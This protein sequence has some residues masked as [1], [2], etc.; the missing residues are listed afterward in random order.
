MNTVFNDAVAELTE[1]G[2]LSE[3]V[4][5]ESNIFDL[6][7]AVDA[8]K[9]HLV[10]TCVPQRKWRLVVC[11]DETAA[12]DIYEGCRFSTDEVVYYP[13]KD[14]LFYQSDIRSN[15]LN[16]ER[17][18]A[19]A[20]LLEKESG[21]VVTT[22][23]ALM[24]RIPPK[25]V[26]LRSLV[27]IAVDDRLELEDMKKRLLLLGYEP[28]GSVRERGEFAARGG[29]VDVFPLNTMHPFRIEF[30][31]DMVDSIR[32]FDEES[33][34][35]ID[36]VDVITIYPVIEVTLEDE[37]LDDALASMEKDY[38][39]NYERL[40]EEMRT[41]EAHRLKQ[42]YDQIREMVTEG[43]YGEE[44]ETLL[45]YFCKKTAGLLDYFGDDAIIFFDEIRHIEERG[46]VVF[47]EFSD[48]I[49]RRIAAG[50]SLPKTVEMMQSEKSIFAAL[51]KR[52]GIILSALTAA[53]E[54]I[55][56]KAHFY[57]H[58]VSVTAFNQ[59]FE[60]FIKELESYRKQKYHIVFLTASRTRGKRIEEDLQDRGFSVFYTEDLS[61]KVH[62]G[63][64]MI[65]L[66]SISRGYAFPDS[67]YV[68][69]SENDLFGEQRSRRRRKKRFSGEKLGGISELHIGDYVV[70]ENY[71]LGI[72]QGM[73]KIEVERIAKDYIKIAYAKGSNLYIP[74]TQWDVIGKYQ[75]A[76][77]GKPK[78]ATLGTLEWKNTKEKVRGAVATVAH[79]LVELY[80]LRQQNTGFVYG[81][82]TVW[83]KEF[84][85]TFP[86]EET[87]S[88][89]AAI[90]DVKKDMEST[91]IMD[92]L[93]CG[94]VG[95]GKTEIAI[96]AAFKAVQEGKQVV[97]LCPTTIL[98]N[99][100]YNTFRVR[101]AGYPVN[102]GM[103]S[104]FRSARENKETVKKL[105]KGEIDIVIG[106]HRALSKDVEYKDLGLLII[107]EE[108]RFGVNHKEKIKQ[109]KKN[110]DVMSL[111]ATPIPRTLHMSL[112]GIRD[113]SVLEEAPLER[114]P[115]QTY[116]FEKNDEMVREA[117]VREMARGGQVYYVINRVRQIADVAASI[118]KLVPEASV[119]YA[120]GQMSKSRLEMIMS[121]FI[122]REIDVLV[123]TTIIEIGLDITN[124]NTIIIHDADQLGL[125]QLYQLRGRV[126]RGNRTAYAFLMY[127]RN[128]MLKEV[129]E[130]RLSAIREFTDLGSG[131]KIAMRDLE[132]RGA[133]TMLGEAQSGHMEA[134]GYD[135]YCK[136]L[137]EAVRKEKGEESLEDFDTTVDIEIDAY[138]PERYIVDEADKLDIYKRIAAVETEEEQDE[139][140]EE[141]VDRY[142]DVP[143]SVMNLLFVARLK[144]A[145]HAAYITDL[146]QRG[147]EITCKLYERAKIDP[148]AI[149][150]L[151]KEA[152]P[153]LSFIPDKNTPAFEFNFAKN[154][155]IQPKEIPDYL[156]SFCHKVS[157]EALLPPDA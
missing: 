3:A 152:A 60:Q 155:K 39:K 148:L 134:V 8:V 63:E 126:G 115:I 108:Q 71:G 6:T 118:E 101:M 21:I 117:I 119:A 80:A 1:L 137:N 67:R 70:H 44:L 97:Y 116:V 132:I 84:E 53:S 19:I 104:R 147:M 109:M 111:S 135:L 78:L 123:A 23:D 76:G 49:M 9:P 14:L 42:T 56:P 15:E 48:S 43:I 86:Y 94:D 41:E 32:A 150:P 130:K 156:F 11:S 145:A 57:I 151:L 35:S 75:S 29:I 27:T 13:A 140:I 92:R 106:T 54:I 112:V 55:R 139:M 129:A 114:T 125:S 99:Q 22:I 51:K 62:A 7:G 157:K 127:R 18:T 131:F 144:A 120:H 34:K 107:D 128:K 74:A 136:L 98:C 77:G 73:E 61:H 142:G 50:F 103:L 52:S 89:L 12:K 138:I 88:Q 25:E 47:E 91:R 66:A 33:Q 65:A 68:F 90:A 87:E 154:K 100:H 95:Y 24:N 113:M 64:I 36:K 141:L 17:Q 58:A 105:K 59:S 46:R 133:G 10:A 82:D 31:D 85:E 2:T 102:I 143:K 69:I 93:I 4:L 72:Y 30:W 96:R 153:Y 124:V 83:Q 37:A 20:L 122:N 110:V 79:E 121:D 38:T 28:V 5:H 45:P 146:K 16:K 26:F 40:R 149:P 81:P